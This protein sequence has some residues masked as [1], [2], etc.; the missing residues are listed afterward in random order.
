MSEPDPDSAAARAGARA[1]DV[2]APACLRD[3]GADAASA[4]AVDSGLTEIALA[5]A[6]AF[7]SIMV[8]AMI[9]LSVPVLRDPTGAADAGGLVVKPAATAA[10]TDLQG[11]PGAR[12]LVVLHG[13][14]FLDADLAPLA[15]AAVE[16][17]VILAIAP[18]LPL[19]QA[20]AARR[21]LVAADVIV[22]TLDEPWLARLAELTHPEDE[23]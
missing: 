3:S 14:R 6:M 9:S 4:S 12:T 17:P 11:V 5:L 19:Q 18:T 13:G 21:E 10:A 20:I 1:P 15:P 23:P 22:S 2:R 7:F 8:L 16:G